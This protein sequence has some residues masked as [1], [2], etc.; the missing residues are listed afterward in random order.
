ML[1]PRR[2]AL[3]HR[4]A[5]IVNEHDVAIGIVPAAAILMLDDARYRSARMRD[6]M[7]A[8]DAVQPISPDMRANEALRLL[9]RDHTFL[10]PVVEGGR[11]LGVIGLDQIISAL[12]TPQPSHRG[13]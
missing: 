4:T 2:V 3:D 7:I 12:R 9:Q 11:L 6:V 1:V 5:F 13:L 8:A 10:L